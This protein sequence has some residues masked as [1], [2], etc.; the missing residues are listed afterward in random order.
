VVDAVRDGRFRVWSV[1]SVDEAM[2]LLTGLPAGTADDQGALPEGSVNF[3]VS[4][5]LQKLARMRRE[6]ASPPAAAKP[7]EN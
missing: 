3:R 2:E 1:R 7:A 6:F 5:G 4:A